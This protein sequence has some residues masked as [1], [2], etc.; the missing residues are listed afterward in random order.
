[1]QAS[2]DESIF[3]FENQ[4]TAG[5]AVDYASTSYYTGAQI[6]LINSQLLVL[7]SNLIVDTPENSPAPSPTA[8]RCR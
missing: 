6:G 5:G 1:L 8:I 4:F 2:D 7:P 3:G